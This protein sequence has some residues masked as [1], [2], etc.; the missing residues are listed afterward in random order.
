MRRPR[1]A[2]S[3]NEQVV[4]TFSFPAVAAWPRPDNIE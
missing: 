1:N 2:Q 4:A 3:V